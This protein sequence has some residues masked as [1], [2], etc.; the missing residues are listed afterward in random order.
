MKRLWPLVAALALAGCHHAPED[1]YFDAQTRYRQLVDLGTRPDD[2]K[3]D[4]VMH[5]LEQVPKS[6]PNYPKAQKLLG[7]IQA[8]RAPKPPKPLAA[9]GGEPNETADVIAQREAC[10][11][12]AKQLGTADAGLKPKLEAA[13]NDCH[14]RLEALQEQHEKGP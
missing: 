1:P 13:I 10:E 7:G 2:P 11:A 12:L 6:S 9:P 3:F 5:E 8:A 4:P 14:R